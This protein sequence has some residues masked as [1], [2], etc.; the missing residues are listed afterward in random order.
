MHTPPSTVHNSTMQVPVVVTGANGFIG[1]RLVARLRSDGVLVRALL[2]EGEAPPSIWATDSA[3]EVVRGD[4]TDPISVAAAVAGASGVFNLAALVAESS[5]DYPAHWNVT[6]LGSRNVYA[7]ALAANARLVVTTSI[8][9]YG[10]RVRLG[11][12]SEDD[13]RGE[14]QGPYGRAKQG[15]EDFAHQ[16]IAAGLR[17][18]IV[19]PSNVYG[20]GS[21]PWVD[22]MAHLL[23]AGTFPLLDDGVG[24]A[25]LV[26]VDNL[27]DAL[28]LIAAADQCV[29]RTYN[30]CDGLDVTWAH[31]AAD[32]GAMIGAPTPPSVPSAL[33]VGAAIDNEDPAN[34]VPPREDGVPPL[35]FV[36]LIAADSNFPTD[37][38]RADVGWAPT[39]TYHDALVE[40]EQALRTR[41]N[42]AG[43]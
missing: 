17:G 28:V 32:L 10:D 21:K 22:I 25:G 19:R 13:S 8:C 1:R 12:C 40:I 36:N 37:R 3:V 4:V 2:M 16:A 5:G 20:A 31:Y 41:G 18:T 6:A 27:V 29:G 9:A 33:L 43:D 38:V 42:H 39:V 11:S 30:V 35:E 23:A 26:H 15:Q 7:A 24:N 34:Q 14:P